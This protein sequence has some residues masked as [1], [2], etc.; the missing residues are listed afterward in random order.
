MTAS[1]TAVSQLAG[2]TAAARLGQVA[3]YWAPVPASVG[4]RL[5]KTADN[6]TATAQACTNNENANAEV[7]QEQKI[8]EAWEEPGQ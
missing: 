2:W 1:Q 5:K 6:L 3:G 4:D 7:W 8:G